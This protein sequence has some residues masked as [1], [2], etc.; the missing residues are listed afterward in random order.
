M[1]KRK[2]APADAPVSDRAD[3][4]I[5][6]LWRGK[7]KSADLYDALTQEAGLSPEEAMECAQLELGES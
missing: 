4:T 3:A 2:P 6:R 1:A 5:R 7:I